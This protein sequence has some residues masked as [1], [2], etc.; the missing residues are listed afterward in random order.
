MTLHCG[1]EWAQGLSFC[2][3]C[4]ESLHGMR[5]AHYVA[6]EVAAGGSL[7]KR[8]TQC[9][10]DLSPV[11]VKFNTSRC[12]YC[13]GLSVRASRTSRS[14]DRSAAP[15]VTHHLADLADNLIRLGIVVSL[16][17]GLLFLFGSCMSAANRYQPRDSNWQ[18]THLWEQYQNR[19]TR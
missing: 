19:P 11:E 9:G 2:G 15:G 7:N 16:V 17:T 10:D 18:P 3:R 13:S 4:G 5:G 12:V 8:C 14:M 1:R 6:G